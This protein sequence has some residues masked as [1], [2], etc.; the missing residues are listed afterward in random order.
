PVV[1]DGQEVLRVYGSVGHL[2]PADRAP[3]IEHRILTLAERGF[4]GEIV[5][6]P[7]PSERTTLLVAGPLLVIGVTHG[8]ARAAGVP[9]AELARRYASSISKVVETYRVRHTWHTFLIGVTKALVAWTLF[10]IP[11]WALWKAVRW[12][13]KCVESWF[14]KQASA[15]DTQGFRRLV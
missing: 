9:Q 8:G 5:T 6:R 15:R 14:A 1:I 3:E 10:G 7:V 13:S 2:G 12:L 11:V 4:S